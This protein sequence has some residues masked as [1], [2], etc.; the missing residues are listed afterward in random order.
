M[1]SV[2]LY[3]VT[4]HR[5]APAKIHV[6]VVCGLQRVP[7]LEATHLRQRGSE[8]LNYCKFFWVI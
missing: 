1:C 4:A 5:A 3:F 6:I 7:R 2:V 8:F